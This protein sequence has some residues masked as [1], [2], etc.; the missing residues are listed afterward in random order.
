MLFEADTFHPGRKRQGSIHTYMLDGLH[1]IN[2]PS[3]TH[4]YGSAEDVPEQLLALTDPERQLSALTALYG[5]IFHQGSRYPAT[6]YAVPFLVELIEAGILRAELLDYLKHLVAGYFSTR[7]RGL[8]CNGQTLHDWSGASH[9]VTSP[10]EDLGYGTTPRLLGAIW[11]RVAAATPLWLAL[12]SDD[13][14]GIRSRAAVLLA[15]LNDAPGV[16]DALKA[17]LPVEPSGAVRGDL[18]FALHTVAPD[19]VAARLTDEDLRCRFTAALCLPEHDGSVALMI[20]GLGGIEGI[21][22]VSCVEQDAPA[23]A[24]AALLQA[25]RQTLESAIPQLTEAMQQTSGF[26]LVPIV[27]ALLSAAFPAPRGA[28]LTEVQ[29]AVL[30]AM[31]SNPHLW[32]IGNL[33][34]SFQAL[35]IPHQRSRVANLLEVDVPQD[36]DLQAID[37]GLTY[38]RMGFT[39]KAI[40]HLD[41]VEVLGAFDQH[42]D[43]FE[44][45]TGYATAIT[46]DPKRAERAVRLWEE[47]AA[48]T[49]SVGAAMVNRA[50]A[51]QAWKGREAEVA[52]LEELTERFADEPLVWHT[53]GIALRHLDRFEDALA[54]TNR[55]I[56]LDAR[57]RD[58]W[59]NRGSVLSLLGRPEEA[60]AAVGRCLEIDPAVAKQLRSD[61]DFDAIRQHPAFL[62]LF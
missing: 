42:P 59:W 16:T 60:I 53:L 6:P 14:A 22:A 37:S 32:K 12:L 18:C 56:A 25:P 35:N 13:D 31:V 50:L 55:A 27:T 15:L 29:H 51:I 20:A 19:L 54:A 24:A 4:A 9:P 43:G 58:A 62:A 11:Q 23:K 48:R 5:N 44:A 61:A 8:W 52:A 40:E 2:W 17:R 57:H 10:D 1:S 38:L 21:E 26:T 34:E 3:L 28:T 46:R 47:I 49:P 39:D 41:T 36:L 33:W 45:M 7:E 30:A